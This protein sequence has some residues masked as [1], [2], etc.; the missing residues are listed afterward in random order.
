MS[1]GQVR[2]KITDDAWP[3]ETNTDTTFAGPLMMHGQVGQ[4]PTLR[5]QDLVTCKS[6][7]V[8]LMQVHPKVLMMYCP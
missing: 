4:I 8:H 1:L 3:H 5:S 2:Q 6:E 7:H